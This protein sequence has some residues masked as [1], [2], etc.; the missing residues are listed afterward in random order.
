M[1]RLMNVL[2]SVALAT[3]LT[4]IAANAKTLASPGNV[5]TAPHQVNSDPLPVV[6]HVPACNPAADPQ[7]DQTVVTSGWGNQ[8]YP[9]STGG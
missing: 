1:T 2:A 7:T 4:P 3:A 6:Q 8:L 9:E 5:Q